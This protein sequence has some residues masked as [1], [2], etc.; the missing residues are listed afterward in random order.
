M[1]RFIVETTS[2]KTDIN[3]NRYHFATI[4]ST[5]TGQSLAVDHVGGDSNIEHRLREA[6]LEWGEMKAINRT[7]AIREW[8]R[9]R[10]WLK[11]P[12]FEHEV[13]DEMILGLE[14]EGNNDSE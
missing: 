13:T 8:Q 11:T 1:I 2:S 7:E 3:G 12:V 14:R 5:K 10:K 4:T 6:G 9:Q